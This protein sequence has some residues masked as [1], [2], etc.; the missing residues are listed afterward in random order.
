MAFIAFLVLFSANETNFS[1]FSAFVEPVED[2]LLS[3]IIPSFSDRF[4]PLIYTGI[5]LVIYK[6][7]RVQKNLEK[8]PGI[9]GLGEEGGVQY[10]DFSPR[11]GLE[12][13]P[14]RW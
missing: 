11:G 14:S 1:R 12:G 5:F 8:I 2:A 10:P 3:S 4:R 9:L 13:G 6:E 7:K